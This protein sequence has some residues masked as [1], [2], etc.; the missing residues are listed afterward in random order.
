MKIIW[1]DFAIEN[2][3]N[4]FKYYKIKAST[5]VAHE[6]RKQIFESTK[7]LINNPESG[8]VEFHL[9][10][11]EQNH[12]YLLSGNY[13]VIYKIEKDRIF[14]NDVFDV[15]QNPNRMIKQKGLGIK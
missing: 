9:E 12:R 11:L 1:S 5:K 14:V 13:K 10:K 6:I 15:R 3:K 8:Q 2:L 4:I 7:K